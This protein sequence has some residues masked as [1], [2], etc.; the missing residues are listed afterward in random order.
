MTRAV[1][2]AQKMKHL[3]AKNEQLREA[4]KM[5]LDNTDVQVHYPY[6]CELARAALAEQEVS[7]ET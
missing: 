5:F 7:D 3:E 2:D 1:R 4:L 6:E